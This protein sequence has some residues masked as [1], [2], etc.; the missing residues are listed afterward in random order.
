MR[1]GTAVINVN[2]IEVGAMPLEQYEE[3]VRGVKKDWRT[4]IASVF[5]YIGFSWRVI[6]ILWNYFVQS[7]CIFMVI[8]LL[9]FFHHQTELTQ[10]ITDLR[11]ASSQHI[12]EIIRTITNTCVVL[13]VIAGSL[14]VCIKGTPVYVSATESAINKKIREVMEV[15]AEGQVSIIFKKD[16]TYGVR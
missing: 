3:I 8:F 7:L 11:N 13:T 4:R 16:G 6:L 2:G 10:L 9:Y 12:A 14:S 1:D 5:S 15:P